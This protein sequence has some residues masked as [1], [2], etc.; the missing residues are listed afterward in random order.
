[1]KKKVV[2]IGAGGHAKVIVD[3]LRKYE[4]YEIL[5]LLDIEGL[6]KGETVLDVPILGG[7]SKLQELFL[8][9]VKHVFMAFAS[10]CCLLNWLDIS[11]CT[12]YRG[13]SVL[14]S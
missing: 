1:M 3:I 12:D 10:F 2:G 4:E 8:E 6:R 13:F 11:F 5:G 14:Y 7:Q 9:D